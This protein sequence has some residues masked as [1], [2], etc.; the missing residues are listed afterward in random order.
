M[1]LTEWAHSTIFA[2][3]VVNTTSFIFSAPILLWWGIP[4][5][6]L[7]I[8]GNIFFGPFLALFII[9]SSIFTI[10]S[11]VGLNTSIPGYCL[12]KLT[13]YWMMI[14]GLGSKKVLCAQICNPIIL[15][16]M[17]ATVICCGYFL[18]QSKTQKKIAQV[19]LAGSTAIVLLFAIPLSNQQSVMQ[20]RSGQLTIIQDNN[21]LKLLDDGYLKN[22]TNP[23]KNIPFNLK[24]PIVK[25]HGTI[26]IDSLETTKAS[27]RTFQALKEL[28]ICM[29][30]QKII[31]PQINPPQKASFWRALYNL[32]HYAK[33]NNVKIIQRP[34]LRS[35]KENRSKIS[36]R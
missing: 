22:L 34:I 3:L 31:L 11:I 35:T 26:K 13:E 17:I 24:M 9:F 4:I 19:L 36:S 5:S 27:I 6:A 7:S 16:L 8:I 30:T 14:L 23:S 15:L 12:N 20:N 25:N 21:G 2:L 1:K 10:A 33:I 28:I 18:N 29:D 32:R